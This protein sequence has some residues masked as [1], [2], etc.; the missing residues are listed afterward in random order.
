MRQLE[1]H[2]RG[3][4]QV[5]P[6]LSRRFD[7]LRSNS[8]LRRPLL[9]CFLTFLWVD[10]F[11]LG[12]T[13]LTHGTYQSAFAITKLYKTRCP[14]LSF[15]TNPF[16][17]RKHSAS[18]TVFPWRPVLSLISVGHEGERISKSKMR[19]NVPTEGFP[20]RCII[21]LYECL[22]WLKLSMLAPEIELWSTGGSH[23]QLWIHYC[24]HIERNTGCHILS[25]EGSY[26]A[27]SPC[28]HKHRQF[29]S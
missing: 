3:L 27:K 2:L 19:L 4:C 10:G 12:R 17:T 22:F 20:S 7:T 1:H 26:Y 29:C 8:F 23:Y 18:F 11:S 14:F 5:V 16:C 6:N 24:C 25:N 21:T 9:I 15:E 13:N 28:L